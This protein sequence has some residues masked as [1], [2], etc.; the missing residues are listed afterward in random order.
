MFTAAKGLWNTSMKS[1]TKDYFSGTEKGT[2]FARV[3]TVL[4][5]MLIE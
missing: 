3:K 2:Y 5:E 4:S 1:K